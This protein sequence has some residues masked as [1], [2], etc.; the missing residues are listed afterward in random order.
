[1]NVFKFDFLTGIGSKRIIS[2]SGN[3][4]MNPLLDFNIADSSL[5]FFSEIRPGLS[6]KPSNSVKY[7]CLLMN[8]DLE[9]IST[10]RFIESNKK[11]SQKDVLF[12]DKVHFI[13]FNHLDNLNRDNFS[14]PFIPA[15][16]P[17]QGYSTARD[18]APTTYRTNQN[19]FSSNRPSFSQI[20]LL[21]PAYKRTDVNLKIIWSDY[22]SGTITDTLFKFKRGKF[23]PAY[24]NSFVSD[25]KSGLLI[26]F[27]TGYPKGG[28][29]SYVSAENGRFKEEEHLMVN[30]QYE[31]FV[32]NTF[33]ISD[34]EFIIPYAYK[35]KFGFLKLNY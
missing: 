20:Q 7:Y 30:P 1:V 6:E 5:L 26:F 14:R 27:A 2:S 16:L 18:I 34:K 29:I 17:I 10:S 33:K 4:F 3:F 15:V 25:N 24:L 23:K 19:R 28:G 22:R 9:E 11:S 21:E 32:L 31:Y 8:K 12:I 35:G 13:A